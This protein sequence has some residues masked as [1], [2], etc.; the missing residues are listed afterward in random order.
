MDVRNQIPSDS[1][2]AHL[3]ES[4]TDLSDKGIDYAHSIYEDGM[5][6][7]SEAQQ[8]VKLYSEELIEHVR[9]HPLKAILIAGGVG[10]LLSAL[11]KK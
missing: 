10:M 11:L 3:N 4:A 7:V 5:K 6:K 9:Q 1:K 2:N 8:E